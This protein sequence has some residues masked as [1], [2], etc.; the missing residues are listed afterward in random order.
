MIKTQRGM[1]NAVDLISKTSGILESYENLVAQVAGIEEADLINKTSTILSGY[2]KL[3]AQ[4][5][6]IEKVVS[7][8]STVLQ[9]QKAQVEKIEKLVKTIE[10][11]SKNV[12]LILKEVQGNKS[13]L[14][15]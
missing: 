10:A 7:Q 6:S 13:I 2:E 12:D 8:V 5:A 3:A 11:L 15:K 1:P 4:V 9:S 14:K